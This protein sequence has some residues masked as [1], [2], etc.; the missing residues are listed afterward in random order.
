MRSKK[1]P[2]ELGFSKIRYKLERSTA[3]V[4]RLCCLITVESLSVPHIS[5]I[6]R[7]RWFL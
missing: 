5:D 7:F 6:K 2:F 4:Y 3:A 1:L